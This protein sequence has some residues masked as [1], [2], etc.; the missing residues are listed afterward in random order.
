MS[1]YTRLNS[2]F[3]KI[4]ADPTQSKKIEGGKLLILFHFGIVG[5]YPFGG[6]GI[7]N[8]EEVIFWSNNDDLH[9]FRPSEE[10][11]EKIKQEQRKFRTECG[12]RTDYG[13]VFDKRFEFDESKFSDTPYTRGYEMAEIEVTY[14]GFVQKPDIINLNQSETVEPAMLKYFDQ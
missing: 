10:W 1:D 14:L 3:G 11:K 7:V 4:L 12:F 2:A 13:P 6:Y 8:E 9:I 5:S